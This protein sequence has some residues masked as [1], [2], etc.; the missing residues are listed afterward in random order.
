MQRFRLRHVALHVSY[1]GH[2]YSGFAAQAR[3]S[4]AGD[5][6]RSPSPSTIEGELFAALQQACL[7]ESD[8]VCGY[9]RC[10]RT[11]RGVSAAGQII[12]LRLRSIARR[13][14]IDPASPGFDPYS[15]SAVGLGNATGVEDVEF[16]ATTATSDADASDATASDTTAS[17]A[18]ASAADAEPRAS[19]PL[20][21]SRSWV[22]VAAGTGVQVHNG[23]EPFPAPRDE[24]DYAATLNTLLPPDIRVLGW[25]DV[26]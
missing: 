24:H 23:G 11:D 20:S 18:T 26:R 6:S 19:V 2:D 16:T 13:V 21:A 22:R 25:A 1:L 7:V 12:S 14:H 10:G 9:T 4:A 8:E 17:D 5:A 3:P 15:A